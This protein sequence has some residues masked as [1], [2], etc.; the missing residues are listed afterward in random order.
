MAS[1]IVGG[2]LTAQ[3]ADHIILGNT[4]RIALPEGLIVE[5]FGRGTPVTV[6]FRSDDAGT[7]VV[8]SIKRSDRPGLPA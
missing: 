4:G 7:I 8:E 6:A 5:Q 1:G 3:H 2:I